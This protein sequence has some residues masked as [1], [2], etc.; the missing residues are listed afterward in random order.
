MFSFSYCFLRFLG[1]GKREKV[2]LFLFF[3]F[4][5]K[6]NETTK[7]D[8]EQKEEKRK[9]KPQRTKTYLY[10]YFYFCLFSDRGFVLSS[11]PSLRQA[12]DKSLRRKDSRK[13]INNEMTETGRNSN[14]TRMKKQKTNNSLRRNR[15]DAKSK[16]TTVFSYWN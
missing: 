15:Y 2:T 9:R 13:E 14:S 4:P 10:F 16:N 5:P 1:K 8:E 12:V 3:V 11:L 6:L 7:T